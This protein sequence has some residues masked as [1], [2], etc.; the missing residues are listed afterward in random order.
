MRRQILPALVVL[1]L[2][3]TTRAQFDDPKPKTD[4]APVGSGSSE[5]RD[6]AGMFSR[7]AVREALAR[8][9]TLERTYRVP[10]T[11]ETVE[12]LRGEPLDEAAQRLAKRLGPQGKGI[13]IL[14]AK[15]DHRLE[16][17]VSRDYAPLNVRA[18]RFAIRDAFLDDFRRGNYDAGLKRGI[19]ALEKVLASS[20]GD[21]ARPIAT[22]T[23]PGEASSPGLL[24][25]NQA[26]LTLAGAKR[27]VAVAESKA[28]DAGYKM[29]I[30]VVDDGGHL[31]A[32]SRMDDARP[33]SVATAITKATSAATYRQATGP[34]G[35]SGSGS[36]PD[37]LLNLSL[38]NA[39][40]AGGAKITTLLGGVPIV[41]DGQVVGAVGCG[42]GTRRAGRRGRPRGRGTVHERPRRGERPGRQVK[43][44]QKAAA[45]M[46]AAGLAPAAVSLLSNRAT[47]IAGHQL[48]PSPPPP[49][50]QS[51]PP[52]R[53][54][55][56][57]R[58]RPSRHRRRRPR[59]R[60]PSRRRR[61]RR[62]CQS[63]PASAGGAA[64]EPG[65]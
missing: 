48:P 65:A 47:G 62:S 24:K 59:H 30:A 42:G 52:P 31:L 11:I 12:S 23:R 25:R 37:V 45:E 14:M 49:P 33:A 28:A 29:N 53:P 60:R 26:K 17:L 4:D 1:A 6:P 43:R 39:A 10:T 56:H 9:V 55:R 46:T 54:S 35:G 61:R 8:L 63:G 58:R 27:L 2:G 13:Y 7:E 44:S 20:L 15:D 32:F 34:L 40:A 22:A 18:K 36:P 50:P 5:I 57:R 64:S 16:V 19:D 38:Q 41:V 51:P 3:S 21:T